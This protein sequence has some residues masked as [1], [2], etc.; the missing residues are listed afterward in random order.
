MSTF[1]SNTAKS[2]TNFFES[3]QSRQSR[4]LDKIKIAIKSNNSDYLNILIKENI[5][6]INK[7]VFP[8]D[9]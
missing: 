4:I 9:E 8:I 7:K 5:I 2:I 3:S 1:L 6:D